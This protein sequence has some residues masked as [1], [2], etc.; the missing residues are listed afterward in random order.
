MPEKER[1]CGVMARYINAD[2]FAKR[3]ELSPAFENAKHS[4][5]LWGDLLQR[6]VLDL[7]DNAPTADVEEV[8]RC[9]E[10]KH[11]RWTQEPCHGRSVPY[12]I[13][14]DR[15]VANTDFCNYGERRDT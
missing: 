6:V 9:G 10:C 14:H 5:V 8:V 15:C 7:L 4:T 12:C 11:K 3:I 2:R 13:K 1:R